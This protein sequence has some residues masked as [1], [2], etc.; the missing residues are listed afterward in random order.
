MSRALGKAIAIVKKKTLAILL[1]YGALARGFGM[2]LDPTKRRLQRRH[3]CH[4]LGAACP[5]RLRNNC[6][7]QGY[8]RGGGGAGEGLSGDCQIPEGST[9]GEQYHA[10]AG[11]DQGNDSRRKRTPAVRDKGWS[12]I[13]LRSNLGL[14]VRT[15]S[16]SNQR[17]YVSPPIVVA[18]FALWLFLRPDFCWYHVPNR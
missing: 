3:I 10:R 2:T 16:R 11:Y 5:W 6:R 4:R 15:C 18:N 9:S 12:P 14:R 7:F 13:A 8:V 17:A 1:T